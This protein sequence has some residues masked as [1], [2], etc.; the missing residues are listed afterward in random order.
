MGKGGIDCGR[1]VE[2]L[3]LAL[4]ELEY[5]AADF[6][7]KKAATEAVE[8]ADLQAMRLKM[9]AATRAMDLAIQIL[10]AR[11]APIN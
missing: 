6:A 4:I 8:L 10:G 3:E 11:A 1:I 7:H 5:A 9:M 2:H